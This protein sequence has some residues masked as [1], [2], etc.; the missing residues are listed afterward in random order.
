MGWPSC[1]HCGDH[2][3]RTDEGF[4]CDCLTPKASPGATS[5]AILTSAELEALLNAAPVA[6][7]RC[8][9]IRSGELESFG[10]VVIEAPRGGM[11]VEVCAL[12]VG[13]VRGSLGDLEPAT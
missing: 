7:R 8:R 10:R 13:I 2:M 9:H 11:T 6:A 4:A 12:C 1:A 5:A 3:M